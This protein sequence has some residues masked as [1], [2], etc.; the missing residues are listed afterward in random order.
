LA[1]RVPLERLAEEICT[2]SALR[3]A[4]SDL[5]RALTDKGT[6]P[7]QLYTAERGLVLAV[8]HAVKASR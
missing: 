6:T 7:A 8:E 3:E 1:S 5:I 2:S 4:V